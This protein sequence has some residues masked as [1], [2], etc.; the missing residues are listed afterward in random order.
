MARTY[1]LERDGD[2]AV[3]SSR[4]DVSGEIRPNAQIT[5]LLIESTRMEIILR[6]LP[7]MELAHEKGNGKLSVTIS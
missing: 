6:Q 1:L 5:V 3:T 4:R 2:S 7:T